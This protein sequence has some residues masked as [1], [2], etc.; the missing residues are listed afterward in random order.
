MGAAQAPAPAKTGPFLP[1]A[2]AQCIPVDKLEN[3]TLAFPA[4]ACVLLGLGCNPGPKRTSSAERPPGRRAM[5][6][7][8]SAPPR[9]Q[10]PCWVPDLS[11]QGLKPEHHWQA[12]KVC[13]KGSPWVPPPGAP[14]SNAFFQPALESGHRQAPGA[15]PGCLPAGVGCPQGVPAR[16][17]PEPQ[18][19]PPQLPASCARP[20]GP[21]VT[22]KQLDRQ[23]GA[24][25]AP[26]QSATGPRGRGKAGGVAIRLWFAPTPFVKLSPGGR[27]P[28]FPRQ[29]RPPP[30]VHGPPRPAARA[31]PGPRG[32]GEP[33]RPASTLRCWRREPR[34]RPAGPRTRETGTG[35]PCPDPDARSPGEPAAPGGATGLRAPDRSPD[36]APGAP[37]GRSRGAE[38][39]GPFIRNTEQSAASARLGTH[40]PARPHAPR[41]RPGR[42][43][44]S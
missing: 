1:N 25:Q 37:A 2:G 42:S 30:W 19:L 24:R 6:W 17:P 10:L 21:E 9:G 5:A 41:R 35:R 3:G 18:R 36:P 14:S 39:G 28:G 43:P 38:R 44:E 7:R 40:A 15:L 4:S 22:G 8:H 29:R 34:V 16:P 33:G 31:S 12:D 23:L 27:S 13:R 32:G 26:A 11:R 20:S